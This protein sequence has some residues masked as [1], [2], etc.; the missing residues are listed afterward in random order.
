M[1]K[2]EPRRVAR[3]KSFFSGGVGNNLLL[4]GYAHTTNTS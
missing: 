1:Q 4:S 3:S 2:K